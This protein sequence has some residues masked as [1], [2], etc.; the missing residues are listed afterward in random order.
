MIKGQLVPTYFLLDEL[1]VQN[2]LVW[3]KTEFEQVISSIK[4]CVGASWLLIIIEEGV[5]IN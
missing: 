3:S 4:K 2:L 5:A 1:P